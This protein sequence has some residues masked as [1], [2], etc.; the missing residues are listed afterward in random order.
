[1]ARIKCARELS[2]TQLIAIKEDVKKRLL[3]FAVKETGR[4][5]EEFCV[6]DV[7]ALT[8]LGLDSEIWDNEASGGLTATTW[9]EDWKKELPKNKFIAFYGFVNHTDDP[10]VIGTK[11]KEG[12]EGATTRDIVMF[13]RMN[14][15]DNPKCFFEPIIYKGGETIYIEHYSKTTIVEAAELLEF[16]ALVADPYGEVISKKLPY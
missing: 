10:Q 14:M 9:T 3:D 6:R 15:E 2:T 12:G 1:M 13:G 11:F 5:R 7:L 4:K 8:D 16:I